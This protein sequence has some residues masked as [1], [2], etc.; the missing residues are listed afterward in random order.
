MLKNNNNQVQ[1]VTQ[2]LASVSGFLAD[3]RQDLGAALNQLADALG[4][5]Q[6]F[7]SDNRAHIASNVDKLNQISQILTNER[8]SLAE[9][10]DDA[11]LA[12]DNLLGAYDSTTHTLDGRGFVPELAP[13]PSGFTA[14]TATQAKALPNLPLP[15][16]TVYTTG[17][18]R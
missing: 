5:V 16:G 11:P 3:D 14:V 12:V 10:L 2:Q 6:S 8:S 18:A 4:K 9:A 17:G 7:I 15:L 13:T 1:S